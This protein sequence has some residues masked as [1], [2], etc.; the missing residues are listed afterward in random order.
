M[1]KPTIGT[2]VFFWT[3][4]QTYTYDSGTVVHPLPGELYSGDAIVETTNGSRFGACKEEL[5]PTLKELTE[6]EAAALR[7]LIRETDKRYAVLDG[8]RTKMELEARK[9]RTYVD[10]GLGDFLEDA[11]TWEVLS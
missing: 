1:R 7:K 6:K 11:D 5:W 10:N 2:T 4:T 3:N 8:L 9:N